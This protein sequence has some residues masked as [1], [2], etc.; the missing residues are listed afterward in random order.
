VVPGI[1]P[2]PTVVVA[3]RQRGSVRPMI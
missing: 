2:T 3:F 1:H